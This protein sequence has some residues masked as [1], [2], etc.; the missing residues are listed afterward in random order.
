M[1]LVEVIRAAPK[2]LLL[3]LK[4]VNLLT[5]CLCCEPTLWPQLMKAF[6]FNSSQWT[7][8]PSIHPVAF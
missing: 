3:G 8:L 4:S 6:T 5:V 1:K 7:F 2:P